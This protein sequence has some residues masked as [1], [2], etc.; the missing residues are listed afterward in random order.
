MA[1]EA[2][3]NGKGIDAQSTSGDRDTVSLMSSELA[4]TCNRDVSKITDIINLIPAEGR[5]LEN[6]PNAAPLLF[7]EAGGSSCPL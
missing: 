6:S 3:G 1:V 5:E 7:Q 4:I 2:S